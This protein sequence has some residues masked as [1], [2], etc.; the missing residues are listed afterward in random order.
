M[1]SR[2]FIVLMAAVLIAL[3]GL[4]CEQ[5]P[6][7]TPAVRLSLPMPPGV[8]AGFADETLDAAISPDESQIVFVGT[9]RERTAAGEPAG[10]RQLWRRSFN[11]DRAEPMPGTLGAQQPACKPTGNVIAFFAEGRLKQITLGDGRVHDLADAPAAMGAT[12]LADGSLLFAT[13][14]GPVRR[15]RDGRTTDA[16]TLQTGETAHVFPV[17]SA[18]DDDFVYV[19]VSDGGRRTAHLATRNGA[20]E[21][22]TT[23]GHAALV[24]ARLLH[25]R[26]NVLLGYARD[27]E[28]GDVT[29]RGAPLALNVGVTTTG[30]ALF[31]AGPHVLLHAAAARPATTAVWIDVTGARGSTIADAGEFWQVRLSPDDRRL[32]LSTV[33]P[34]LR[35]LDVAVTA[36]DGGAPMERLTLA[37]AADTDPVW[38]PDGARVLFR[39]MSGGTPDLFARRPGRDEKDEAILRSELDEA[40]TDWRAERILYHARRGGGFDILALDVRTGR[41]EAIAETAF[42]ETDARWSPDGRWIAFVSDES[43]RPDVYVRR[44]DLT[45]VRVSFSGGRRPRWTR[46]GRALLFLRG[47]EVMRADLTGGEP[48]G[49]LFAT[50][51]RLFDA[52]G[53]RDFDVAHQTDRIVA[54]LPIAAES[55]PEV[56]VVLNW[57]SVAAAD[58]SSNF[59]GQSPK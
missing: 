21:L 52:P 26:D 2:A 16:T 28:T 15:L 36:T 11:G 51:Q 18:A 13:G 9:N 22:T 38:S 54:V 20:R 57:R 12:W 35:A 41:S 45:R 47:S 40:P 3:G 55:R 24:D 10:V 8:D 1:I 32:A 29:S 37:L 44:P 17:A 33:D 49:T 43:G 46:D 39:S 48:A 27:S 14:S 34:L 53:I 6:P 23:A 59:K 31:V 7:P 50:P 56:G 30:R 4:A 58:P 25:V 42:N 5:P 19:A